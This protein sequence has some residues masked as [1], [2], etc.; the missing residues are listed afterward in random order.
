[1]AREN[2][3]LTAYVDE[4]A[5][6]VPEAMSAISGQF[7][8]QGRRCKELD[9]ML[10]TH[11]ERRHEAQAAVLD[12]TGAEPEGPSAGGLAVARA[13]LLGLGMVPGVGALA[14]VLDADRLAQ[15]ADRLR[16]G[17]GA[18][19]RNHDD[20]QLVLSPERVLTP[21]LLNE[22]SDAASAAPWIVLF[23]D[24]YE[25]T[26]P[27]LDAWL[28][29]VMT[30]DRYG[31]LPATVV[32][33]TAGRSSFDTARWG[34]FTDFMTDMP[35]EP[36]TEVETRSL[37]AGRGVVAEPVVEERLQSGRVV[38]RT[39]SRNRPRAAF[40]A[41][42]GPARPVADESAS[43]ALALRADAAPVTHPTV[44]RAAN[45]TVIR[46]ADSTVIRAADSTVIR[47]A[48]STVIR[49]ADSTVIRA[50]DSTV[51]QAADSTVN[52]GADPAAGLLARLRVHDSRLL[53]TERDVR[54]LAPAVTAWLERGVPATAVERT[55]T[56]G[57]PQ[58]PIRHP[59]A[60]VRPDPLQTCDGCER[61]FRAPR[62][63]RCR[64][65][66]GSSLT[67]H[68]AA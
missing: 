11:R 63:G 4:S 14:P 30:G 24:T 58:E 54:R 46:A 47:A 34:A 17:L 6:S 55:L 5:G 60:R 48:D 28:H 29:D 43:P 18:R 42:A 32:V 44:S 40:A 23:F 21:V 8:G 35:L 7:A 12:T 2:G 36:F 27:L 19:L 20:A 37:L 52:Q 26:G 9:R 25:R 41:V 39:V 64:D 53:L 56:A 45:P 38:T 3:A 65:C 16:A 50:A 49:A 1:M 61:A 51:N 67:D 33:V 22:L 59:A 66:R 62:P 10:A 15:G 13:G 31:A 57:L 68:V